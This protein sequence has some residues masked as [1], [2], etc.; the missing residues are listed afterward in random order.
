MNTGRSPNGANGSGR[1]GSGRFVKGCAPGPGN[2][3]G[4]M[5]S[6]LRAALVKAVTPED[7][8]AIARGLIREA[9][10]GNCEAARILFSHTLGKPV[11]FDLLER[12]ERLEVSAAARGGT[13]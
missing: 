9:R 11:E 5:V 10:A 12:I 1:D 3:L 13:R 7:V 6:K 4:P 8:R 2:P